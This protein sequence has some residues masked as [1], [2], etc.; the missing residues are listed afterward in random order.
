MA[1]AVDAASRLVTANDGLDVDSIEGIEC[2]LMEGY[3]H[4]TAG[5][6]RRAWIAVRRAMAAAQMMRMHKGVASPT[7]SCL[8][9]ESRVRIKPEQTW[10]SI[11][12]FDRYLSLMLDLPPGS[13]DNSFATLEALERCSATERM[14][15][16]C[17][18]AAGRILQRDESDL[19]EIDAMLQKAS[20][21][22]PAQW[23]LTPS[24]ASFTGDHAAKL[25]LTIRVLVQFVYYHLVSLLHLPHILRFSADS[26]HDYSKEMAVNAS[27][28]VLALYVCAADLGLAPNPYS[29][30]VDFLVLTASAVLS[31][32]HID[33][34]QRARG[35]HSIPF[36]FLGHQRLH[37]RGMLEYA[38]ES[39]E[40]RAGEGTDVV[41]FRIARILRPLLA[42]EADAAAGGSYATSSSSRGSEDL[43]GGGNVSD[44]G[45]VLHVYVPY[46]GA[47]RIERISSA[48]TTS[49]GSL[50]PSG[51]Q[52]LQ[53]GL[54]YPVDQIHEEGET[55]QNHWEFKPCLEDDWGLQGVGEATFEGLFRSALEGQW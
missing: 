26:R 38:L 17:C 41:A 20:A 55:L 22:M 50:P 21:P 43:E 23:W 48:D 14:E 4:H 42:F 35:A 46:F 6:L 28:Q 44:D 12:H 33:A 8:E 18:V 19:Y 39:M 15:R 40:K 5:S 30:S 16:I 11:V 32:A 7:I 9:S 53:P 24:P 29:C 25:K 47:I 54:Q 31:L 36:A 34:H 1:R 45:K 27:R 2:M 3:Y 10:F 51:E 37:D 13:L 49:P 52:G